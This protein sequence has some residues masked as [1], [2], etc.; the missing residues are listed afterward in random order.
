VRIY[1]GLG[2]AYK[3]KKEYDE[4]AKAYKKAI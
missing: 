2:N 1:N 4:A 3:L